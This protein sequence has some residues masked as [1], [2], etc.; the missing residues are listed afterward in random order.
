MYHIR[1]NMQVYGDDADI[2]ILK[3]EAV[4]VYEKLWSLIFKI[5]RMW[6]GDR[7]E[8]WNGSRI[9]MTV[10]KTGESVYQV[11][12]YSRDAEERSYV[13]DLLDSVHGTVRCFMVYEP[14]SELYARC[15]AMR[16]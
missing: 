7:M 13:G 9:L 15:Q 8:I 4:R 14:E 10:N 12:C 6:T 5:D 11:R 16:K 3:D 1:N 2:P